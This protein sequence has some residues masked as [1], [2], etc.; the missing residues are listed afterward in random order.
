[1]AA[2]ASITRP[3]R[4]P[5]IDQ[6]AKPVHRSRQLEIRL[7]NCFSRLVSLPWSP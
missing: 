7:K 6:P 1:M 5:A 2:M 3:V 4:A